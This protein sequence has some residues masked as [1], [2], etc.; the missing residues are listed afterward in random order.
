MS[1]QAHPF[2]LRK[3]PFCAR[4]CLWWL[5]LVCCLPDNFNLLPVDI[6]YTPIAEERHADSRRADKAMYGTMHGT[7][8]GDSRK[9]AWSSRDYRTASPTC[10]STAS[11]QRYNVITGAD[12]VRRWLVPRSKFKGCRA[13]IVDARKNARKT[14]PIDGAVSRWVVIISCAVIVM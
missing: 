2:R 4:L 12:E 11:S 10:A 13:V 5:A 6:Y 7:K 14:L 9:A 1:C 8:K 3:D